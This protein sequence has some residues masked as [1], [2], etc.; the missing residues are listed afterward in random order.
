MYNRRLL[1]VSAPSGGGK[2][3]LCSKLLGR[4]PDLR[5]SVSF[6][7]RLPRGDEE[8]GRDYHFVSREAFNEMASKGAF[9]EWAEV[10]GNLYGTAKQTI[11]EALSQGHDILFDIDWQGALQ[12]KKCYPDAVSVFIV[13]PSLAELERRLRTRGTDTED[14]IRRRMHNARQELLQMSKFDY[15]VVNR[16]IEEA[17]LE[18]DAIFVAE[19]CRARGHRIEKISYSLKLDAISMD[20]A[21]TSTS[22]NEPVKKAGEEAF[23]TR[24]EEYLV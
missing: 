10:H 5:L 14:T 24:F 17:F 2:T 15:I 8:N 20:S 18:L 6:T 1:I 19:G 9:A 13:P 11:D 7:T 22:G 4:H 21:S 23:S 3:T 16:D 12:I